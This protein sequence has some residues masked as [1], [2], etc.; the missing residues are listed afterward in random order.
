MRLMPRRPGPRSA[1]LA[2]GRRHPRTAGTLEVSGLQAPITIARDRWGVPHIDAANDTDAWFGLGFCHGQDRGFQLEVLLRAGR[3]TLAELFGASILPVDRL[4]RTLGFRRLGEAQR[5][6]LDADVEATLTAYVAGV[7]A[8]AAASPRP[9]ELVLLRAHRTRWQVEDVLAFLGLQSLALAGNWDS[10]LARLAVLLA[11][12]PDALATIDQPYAAWLPAALPPG[13]VAGPALER[14]AAD[15]AMLRS[16]VG[17]DG[18]SNAWAVAASRTATGAPIL[19]ND[20]HLAPATPGPWYLAHLRT[21]GWAVAGASFVGGPAFPSA[22]NGHA[23]W[24]I[25]AGCS[26]SSDLFWEEPIGPDAVRGP[27]GPEPVTV[28][29]EMIEV[30]GKPTEALPVLVTPRGPIVTSALDGTGAT[31][32]LR[33]T[34]LEPRPVRGL[35]DV[36][37]ARDFATFRAAFTAWPGP[38]LNVAYADADGHVGYQLIGTLPRRR[39]GNGTLPVPAWEGGWEDEHLPFNDLPWILDPDIGFVATANNAPRTDAADLPFLG[40][41]WLDGYRAARITERLSSSDTW[42][43][44]ATSALQVDVASV[45]WREMRDM[46]LAADVG[47]DARLALALLRGWDGRVSAGSAAASVFEVFVAELAGA[48]ARD[49]APRAWRWALGE[50]FGDGVPRTTFGARTLSHLVGALRDGTDRS[51]Q[52]AAS[53]AAAQAT[54]I[55]RHGTAPSGWAW[56]RVRP[57]MLPHVLG[58]VRPMDRLFNLGPVAAGGDTNTVAQA[59]VLPL[60]PTANAAAIANHRMV[61]DLAD[62]E[63]S[64]FVLAGGQSGNPVSAHY[65]DLLPLWLRGEGIGIAWS[66]EAVERAT[67]DRL[68]LQPA[69]ETAAATAPS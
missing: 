58:A 63:R 20:P 48:L 46:V 32:S 62:V 69:H 67:V 31:L 44:R 6:V 35:L 36:V 12:G 2:L 9:H 24:G 33:A 54:L 25:T 26:D 61:V 47:P 27:D 11:D 56:G 65:D 28:I 53:L 60:H 19:A 52:I 68:L 15:L 8:A 34:W 45:P 57:L 55:E 22:H 66:P 7:N 59:G 64:R 39:S 3:G 43:V 10:E 18:A 49:A 23:A 37:R 17:G 4:V 38:A 41:D 40:V 13:S 1:L 5:R 29:E 42:D 50:G 51:A 14:L 16:L 30:R 21:P